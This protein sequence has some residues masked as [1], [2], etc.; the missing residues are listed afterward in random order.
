MQKEK[1]GEIGGS[2]KMQ[3]VTVEMKEENEGKMDKEG[4]DEEEL[5]G[6]L[7]VDPE[8]EKKKKLELE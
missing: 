1:S 4:E 3:T 6:L 8:M 2:A 5:S 7:F